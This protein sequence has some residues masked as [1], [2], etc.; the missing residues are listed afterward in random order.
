M[1]DLRVVRPGSH[2]CRVM[3]LNA[4][5]RDSKQRAILPVVCFA[6][7]HDVPMPFVRMNKASFS[8]PEFESQLHT[9]S[10]ADFENVKA[11]VAA[12]LSHPDFLRRFDFQRN[13]VFGIGQIAVPIAIEV[14]NLFAIHH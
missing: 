11:R 13:P 7:P 10:R 5:R 4:T 8:D 3:D 9:K 6:F 2:Q 12:P 1:R 14:H